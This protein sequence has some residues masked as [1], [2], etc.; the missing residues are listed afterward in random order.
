M[1]VL[2][3]QTNQDW[4]HYFVCLL[5]LANVDS[6]TLADDPHL[7]DPHWHG[8]SSEKNSFQNVGNHASLVTSIF[9]NI[10]VT[11][12]SVHANISTFLD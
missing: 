6:L 8:W 12:F 3:A 5:R 11:I 2:I 7:G 9:A 10:Q 4:S 1:A